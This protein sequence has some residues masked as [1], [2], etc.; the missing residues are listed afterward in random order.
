MVPKL[1]KKGTSFRGAAAYVLHD[2]GRTQTAR[3]VAWSET[4]NLATA[5]PETAWRVMAATAMDQPRLKAAAGIKNTGRKSNEHVLHFTLSW[6]QDEAGGLTRAEMVRAARGAIT[7]LK[8]DDRQALIVAHNDE[9]QPHIHILLNR[10]SPIDGRSLSSS[11]EKLALSKWAEQYERDRGRILCPE[12]VVNNAARKRGD[13]VRGRANRPRHIFEREAAGDK[14]LAATHLRADQRQKDQALGRKHRSHDAR[15]KQ[16]RETLVVDHRQRLASIRAD[17]KRAIAVARQQVQERFKPAMLAQLRR[18][19]VELEQ[20]RGREQTFLG[21]MANCFKSV[22]LMAMV[23]GEGRQAAISDGF[24]NLASAGARLEYLKKRHGREQQKTVR[25]QRAAE[26]VEVRRIRL[27]EKD[28]RRQENAS[29]TK[30]RAEMI[31]NQQQ[32]K[33]A[34]R[35]AWKERRADRDATWDRFTRERPPRPPTE[36]VQ[37]TEES[38]QPFA[39][40]RHPTHQVDRQ[41]RRDRGDEGGR[42]R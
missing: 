9:P 12:R 27:E 10:V 17:A 31:L 32:D 6:H 22:S 11:K 3:R 35:T 41:P 39:G 20:F 42:S 33:A 30:T 14:S 38:R 15:Q 23:K 40:R 5:N 24:R 36:R 1:H 16:A 4:Q 7:A 29:F 26:V 21:R 37:L 18:Q 8:A 19:E 28:R 13:F 34:V 25:Q 2:K